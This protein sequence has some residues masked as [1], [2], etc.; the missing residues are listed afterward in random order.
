MEDEIIR[1]TGET[2]G[3]YSPAVKVGDYIFVSGQIGF[4]DSQTGEPIQGIENQ[5]KQCLENMK[6]VLGM[7]NSGL[8]SVVKVTVFL[9]SA[10]DFAQMNEIYQ[11]YFLEHRPARSTVVTD[12]IDPNMLIEMDCI[13]YGE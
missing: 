3:P 8:D 10:G 2:L 4:K 9:K 6:R 7:L 13:A 5:T 12:L 11:G 1:L